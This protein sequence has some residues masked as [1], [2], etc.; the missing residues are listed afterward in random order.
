MTRR[1]TR[2]GED[3]EHA[4]RRAFLRQVL[5]RVGEAERAGRITRVHVPADNRSGPAAHAADDRN[6]LPTVR[7]TVADRLADDPAARLEPP[8]LLSSARI[9]G[10]EPAV[11]GPVDTNAAGGD[12]RR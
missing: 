8:Q 5:H 9:D 2:D 11:R 4:S 1:L 6:I 7:A 10:F 12:A 3:I